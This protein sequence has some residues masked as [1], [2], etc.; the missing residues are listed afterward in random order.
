M[1]RL[2][3]FSKPYESEGV[4]GYDGSMS[5]ESFIFE[6]DIQSYAT[7][8]DCVFG[9]AIVVVTEKDAY[10]PGRDGVWAYPFERQSE[11]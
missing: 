8:M 1:I 9:P 2:Q 7:S 5:V 11:N 6:R 3:F 4:Y 10:G